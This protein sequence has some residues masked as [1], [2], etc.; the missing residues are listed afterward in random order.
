MQIVSEQKT[1]RQSLSSKQVDGPNIKNRAVKVDIPDI[2]SVSA[3]AD[4]TL[5]PGAGL[6]IDTIHGPVYLVSN[7]F[8]LLYLHFPYISMI[9]FPQCLFI[10]LF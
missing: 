4:L 7:F 10:F 9:L 3:S 8:Y 2:V 1:S 6:F 5:P